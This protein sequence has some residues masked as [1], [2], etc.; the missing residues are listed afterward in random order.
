MIEASKWIEDT[1]RLNPDIQSKILLSV[2]ILLAL[3]FL[4]FIV[5][6]IVWKRTEDVRTRYLWRKSLTYVEVALTAAIV[7]RIWFEGF[8]SIA[9]FLGLVSAGL[10][11]ALKDMVSN[12]AGWLFIILRRPFTIGDRIEIGGSSGDVIDMRLFQFTILEIGN[13][14][15]ADQS[16]GRVIHIPNGW[17]FSQ[18]LANYSKGFQY[19]WHEIPVLVTFESN[20]HKAKEI[21]LDIANKHTE[22]LSKSAERRIKEASKRFMIFYT[23]LSPYVYTSIQDSGVL[24]TI[25]YLC[26]P[27]KRRSSENAISEDVLFEFAK[28]DDIDFAYPTRRFYN[29]L[30][31]G[32]VRGDQARNIDPQEGGRT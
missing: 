29:N 13:W 24:L 7:G 3:W 23:H 1:L 16:T 31:E 20:W 2:V 21:L 25:R 12:V 8:K 28:C 18:T 15:N 26:E 19:I 11:I 32:K 5:L 9:T 4:R 22:H 14:V 10:A 17:V 27:R 30:M 6:R